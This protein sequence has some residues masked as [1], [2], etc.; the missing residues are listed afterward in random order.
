[1]HRVLVLLALL[2][3][4]PVAA[5]DK[6]L[7]TPGPYIAQ[8]TPEIDRLRHTV[9]LQTQ[10]IE[11][12]TVRAETAEAQFKALATVLDR[13]FIAERTAAETALRAV[14]KPP[15]DWVVDWATMTFKA[16]EKAPDA[17]KKEN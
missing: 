3:A 1:M 8:P 16:P 4:V 17:P 13:R 15:A 2:V 12:L 14:V 9:T 10:M 5:Q 7:V 6:P 11:S